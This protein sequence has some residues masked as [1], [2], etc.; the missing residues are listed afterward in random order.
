MSLPSLVPTACALRGKVGSELGAAQ[1]F[2]SHQ[3]AAQFLPLTGSLLR[4][5]LREYESPHLSKRR[6]SEE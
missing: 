6:T 4:A 3:A 5:D 2:L 1:W